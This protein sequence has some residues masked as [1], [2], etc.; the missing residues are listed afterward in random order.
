MEPTPEPE[1]WRPTP[2]RDGYEVSSLGRVRNART[3]R[4]LRPQLC[5]GNTYVKVHLGRGHQRL[6]HRLVCE[7]FHGAPELSTY[8]ADHR[9]FDTL[10]NRASNL[11]WLPASEN[12]GRKYRRGP[13]GAW[14]RVSDDPPEDHVEMTDAEREAVDAELAAAG[15]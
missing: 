8:H 2:G 7:A 12:S 11:R 6:V 1:E 14:E 4:V 5:S 10:N 13:G 9:D 3:G 15:W